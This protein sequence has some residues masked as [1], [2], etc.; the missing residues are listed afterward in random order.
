MP[1]WLKRQLIDTGVLTPSGLG[2]KAQLRRHKPCGLPTLTGLDADLC[3][4]EVSCDLGELTMSGEAMS[5]LDGRATFEVSL[6]GQLYRRD[7]HHI[8]SRPAGG[9]TPVLAQH[10]CA[11]PI[12]AAW[13]VPPLQPAARQTTTEEIP[14]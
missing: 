2:R 6:R 4:F 10:R 12:P 9:K 8:T 1:D 11:A 13:C 3:A 5:L 7:S 14:F